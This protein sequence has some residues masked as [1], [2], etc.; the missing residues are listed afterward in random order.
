M[1]LTFDVPL[2]RLGDGDPWSVILLRSVCTVIAALAIRAAI[3]RITGQAPVLVPGRM[4]WIV[5]ALYALTSLA[6]LLAVFK[7]PTANLVFIL[8]L[9]PM[10]AALFARIFLGER[11]RR[12]TIIAMAAMA[13]GVWLIVS[14]GMATGSLAGNL[15]AILAAVSLAAAL[16]V[17]RASGK[18]MGFSAV[19]SAGFLVLIALAVTA[20]SGYHVNAP[21]W[22]VLDGVVMTVALYCLAV[23][24][25]WLTGPEVGM[26][27]MLETVL[28]P[29][30]VWLIF[31]EVPTRNTFIG[32]AI[33]IAALVIHTLV[34]IVRERKRRLAGRPV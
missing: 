25:K 28:A 13:F 27:Y 31:Y 5:A 19:L 9:N 33:V 2:I 4:G 22:V 34:Q 12:E 29:V 30:W 23:G 17:S 14:D 24:P 7:T 10:L 3:Q 20:T 16:T 26:F 21:H 18:D 6:F 8:A 11:M 15:L 32:G 1:M